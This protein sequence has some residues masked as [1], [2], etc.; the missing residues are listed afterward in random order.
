MDAE[1]LAIA[2]EMLGER[3]RINLILDAVQTK[4]EVRF[5]LPDL[6]VEQTIAVEHTDGLCNDLRLRLTQVET[7]LA[8]IGVTNLPKAATMAELIAAQSQQEE[9]A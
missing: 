6:D 3:N 8:E 5:Y 4:R 1:D 2:A 7:V 9:A